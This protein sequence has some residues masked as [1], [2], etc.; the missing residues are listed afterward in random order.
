MLKPEMIIQC[1]EGHIKPEGK[2]FNHFQF[3]DRYGNYQ[4][5]T[6]SVY[7]SKDDQPQ[8]IHSVIMERAWRWFRSYLEQQ[9]I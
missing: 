3:Q 6:L 1:T 2:T 4:L 9:T 5:W 8:D 7:F